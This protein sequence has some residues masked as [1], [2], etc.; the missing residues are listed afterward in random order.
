VCPV[1]KKVIFEKRESDQP[2]ACLA[3]IDNGAVKPDIGAVL[4]LVEAVRG[5]EL[6]KSG[7]ARGKIVLKIAD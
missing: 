1:A 2:L 7:R 3:L 6:S 5:Y 4:P